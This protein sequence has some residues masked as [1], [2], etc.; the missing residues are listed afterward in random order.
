MRWDKPLLHE[1]RIVKRFLWL[2]L[3]FEDRKA[4]WLEFA[5]IHQEYLSDWHDLK[6]KSVAWATSFSDHRESEVSED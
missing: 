6:W 2:P 4:R 3:Y 1:T 5:Y